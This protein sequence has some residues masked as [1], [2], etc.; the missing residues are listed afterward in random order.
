MAGV[1]FWETTVLR[2]DLKE[3]SQ[4]FLRT[5]RGRSLLVAGPKTEKERNPTVE[6]LVGGIWRLRVSEAERRVRPVPTEPLDHLQPNS[7]WLC[8]SRSDVSKDWIATFK[9]KVPVS[10]KC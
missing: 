5:G 3:S 6:S 4:R 1:L 10:F 8:V 7:V 9:V 2:L